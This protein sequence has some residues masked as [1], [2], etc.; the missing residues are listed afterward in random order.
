MNRFLQSFLFPYQEE[1]DDGTQGGAGGEQLTGIE[2]T[3]AELRKRLD[4]E[5]KG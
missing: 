1:H 2:K 3:R 4:A 5:N